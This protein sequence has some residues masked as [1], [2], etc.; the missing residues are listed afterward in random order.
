MY[1][2][3]SYDW[4]ELF[5]SLAVAEDSS[6]N[7]AFERAAQWLSHCLE[8]DEE[9]RPRASS[10][11]PRRLLDV[12]S[13]DRPSDPFLLE[14]TDPAPYVCLSYCWGVDTEGV[15]KSTETNLAAHYQAVP[16]TS[17]P[18]TIQ[19]AVTVCRRLKIAYLWVDSLCIVQDDI[20]SWLEDS[21]Q[22]HEIYMNCLF[23]IAAQEPASCKSGFLGKQRFGDPEWQRRFVTDVPAMFGEAVKELFIRENTELPDEDNNPF[24]LDTRGWCLQEDLLPSRK[25]SF[26]GNEMTWECHCRRICECGHLLWGPRSVYGTLGA[27]IKTAEAL[28]RFEE[29]RHRLSEPEKLHMS[30]RQLIEAYSSRQLTQPTDKLAAVSGLAQIVA[31]T[32]EEVCGV[33]D[34]YLAGLWRTEFLYDLAWQVRTTRE[35]FRAPRHRGRSISYR[36]PTWSWACIDD[37]VEYKFWKS[38]SYWKYTPSKEDE[39]TVDTVI[40]EHLLPDDHTGPVTSAHAVLTGPLVPVELAVLEPALDVYHHEPRT[41]VRGRCLRPVEIC[42]DEPMRPT[43]FEGDAWAKCWK[44]SECKGGCCVF[45][46]TQVSPSQK[47]Q[48]KQSLAS[49]CFRLFTLRAYTGRYDDSGRRETLPPEM[50]FLVL[51]KCSVTDDTFERIGVGVCRIEDGG[52]CPLFDDA[53]DCKIKIV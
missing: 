27:S 52:G 17:M 20:T 18:A 4:P 23:T 37:P 11:M 6:S 12:G 19:D 42:L 53:S 15:L 7:M 9:C 44:Q 45:R 49:Y 8:N 36:A 35:G 25:L 46:K 31:R 10:F 43:V 3:R 14:P 50:W 28:K 13:M 5:P 51:R 1:K 30:W 24:S 21:A 47:V 33:S 34:E 48:G 29:G 40:C 38:A 39:S 32:R 26:N 22:M 41:L 2:R 16:Y